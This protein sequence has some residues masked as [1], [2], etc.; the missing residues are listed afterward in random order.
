[1][2]LIRGKIKRGECWALKFNVFFY[3][4]SLILSHP[5]GKLKFEVLEFEVFKFSSFGI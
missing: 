4:L 2:G 1:M 5:S 3:S